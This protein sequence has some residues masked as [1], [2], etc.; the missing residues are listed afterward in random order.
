M[1]WTL[2]ELS[3]IETDTL[4]KSVIDTILMESNIMELIPWETI[5]TLSTTVVMIQDLPSVGFRKIN[6][7][8]AESTGHFKQK[9]ENISLLGG[10]IDTDKA[11]ARAK[12][13]VADARAIQQQM[14]VKSIAYK[15][16]DRFINGDP[17]TDPEEFRGIKSRVDEVVA[18][19]YTDQ[20]IDLGGTYGAARDAGILYDDASGYNFLVKL[21]QLIYSI[22]GH[23]PDFLLMNKKTLLAVK[24]LMRR[25]KLLDVT[26]DMFDRQIDSYGGARMIDIGTLSD[27]LTEIITN[28]EDPQGLYTSD[29]STSI[30]AVKFGIGEFLWGI[31]EYPIEVT[32]KGLLEAMPVYR[33]EV[34]WPLGL[35]HIDPKCIARLCNI[36]PD[37]I[38]QS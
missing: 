23:N 3:K 38:I 7:G 5:G 26:K 12:N 19:G 28:T 15:F 18:E 17:V 29:I 35:A 33:T 11:L 1:A 16:N 32:D 30:Y 14:M 21:D 9:A 31:Q 20:L 6:E 22:K 8:Y 27:G 4:R 36:F 2:A 25:L 37:G 13:T 10:M 34:D 24:A